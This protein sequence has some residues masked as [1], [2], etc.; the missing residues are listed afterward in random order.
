MSSENTFVIVGLG[1]PGSK[2]QDTRHNV[3]FMVAD[4][5]ADRAGVRIETE[6]WSAYSAKARVDG[7]TVYFVKPDT[8]MNLSGKAV[9]RFVDYYKCPAENVLII[10]DDLDMNPGR[11]KL[12]DSGGSGG[13]NG[14]KSLIQCLSTKNFFRLKFGIGRPGKNGVHPD[15]PVD[16][17]VLSPFAGDEMALIDERMAIIHEGIGHFLQGDAAKAKNIINSVK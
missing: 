15:F 16:K 8:Y 3:G 5:L 13:H 7:K 2:Y 17:F 6:K 9:V 1:N 4:Y 14:I 11:L 10:H 12:A